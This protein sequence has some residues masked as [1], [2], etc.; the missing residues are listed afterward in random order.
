MLHADIARRLG[1]RPLPPQPVPREALLIRSSLFDQLAGIHESAHCTWNYVKREP[2]HSVEIEGRGNGGGEFKATLT[3]GT[4]E[5]RDDDDVQTRAKL[6]LRIAGALL[7]PGTR[8]SWLARLPGFIVPL[9]AQRRYGAHGPLYDDVCGHDIAVVD[10]ILGVMTRD[11]AE[12]RRLRERVYREA[13]EFVDRHWP[14]IERLGGEIFKRGKLDKRQIE[15][16]LAPAHKP[17]KRSLLESNKPERTL[18]ARVLAVYHE[19]GHCVGALRQGLLIEGVDVDQRG[20]G[21]TRAIDD[22][23][24]PCGE[25]DALRRFC[26]MALCG[27]AAIRKL[28]GRDDDCAH[29]DLREVERRIA[30]LP[31]GERQ[32]FLIEARAAAQRIVDRDWNLLNVLARHLHR[33]GALDRIDVSNVLNLAPSRRA[34]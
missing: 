8:E 10:R 30:I 31:V 17:A 15:E 12:R 3:S 29:D 13:E 11:P 6:D 32:A 23:Q 5:L 9:F 2:I 27:S 26:V 1:Y 16:V 7:D 22:P 4:I 20:G 18:P 25:R 33:C 14:M 24:A 28:T 21:R 34:A 19:S